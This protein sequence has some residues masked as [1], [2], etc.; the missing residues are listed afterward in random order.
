MGG[1]VYLDEMQEICDEGY[2]ANPERSVMKKEGEEFV[3]NLLDSLLTPNERDYVLYISGIYGR[4]YTQSEIKEIL[5]L[6]DTELGNIS[7]SAMRKLRMNG[8]IRELLN[9]TYAKSNR[10][11]ETSGISLV[12][13][14]PCDSLLSDIDASF[15]DEDIF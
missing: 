2:G 5:G 1:V 11:H 15:S 7:K 12:P 14:G 13:S 3:Y 8:S 4:E 9:P 10:T 6:S